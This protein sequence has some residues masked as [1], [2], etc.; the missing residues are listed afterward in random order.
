MSPRSR[1]RG[2]SAAWAVISCEIPPCQSEGKTKPKQLQVLPLH[3]TRSISDPLL[4]RVHHTAHTCSHN[5]GP[6]DWA[7]IRFVLLNA[8]RWQCAASNIK[9]HGCLIGRATTGHCWPGQSL[10]PQAMTQERWVVL[11]VTWRLL[12][13]G[14]RFTRETKTLEWDTHGSASQ[15]GHSV[16]GTLDMNSYDRLTHVF[17]NTN[18]RKYIITIHSLIC[19]RSQYSAQIPS[20]SSQLTVVHCPQLSFKT[21][22]VCL[23][24]TARVQ[25]CADTRKLN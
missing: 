7:G 13:T 6:C 15:A 1:L 3:Q 14:A 8:F 24:L 9:S 5:S 11:E 18:Y 17:L 20:V 19:Y 4:M 16:E 10:A 22:L 21:A 25:D 12:S 2:Y 23:C